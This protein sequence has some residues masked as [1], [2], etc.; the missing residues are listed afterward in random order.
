MNI[1]GSVVKHPLARCLNYYPVQ[2]LLQLRRLVS[3]PHAPVLLD[4]PDGRRVLVQHPLDV[5]GFNV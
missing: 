1:D 4:G 5:L 3:H 2:R